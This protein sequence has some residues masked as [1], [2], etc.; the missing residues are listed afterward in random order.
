MEFLSDVVARVRRDLERD[1]PDEPALMARAISMP[2]SRD[3]SGALKSE[4]PAVIAEIERSSPWS[5]PAGDLDPRTL[6]RAF[7]AAGAAA[8]SVVTEGRH[9][10]GTLSDLRAAHLSTRLP[11]LR[12]DF[13]V[14]PAQV[15]ESRAHGADA[16]LLI[17]AALPG[18]ELGAM[19]R[20]TLDLGMAALA[21]AHSERELERV[22][23][24]E[25]E[26]VCINARDLE[27]LALDEELALELIRRTS[28]DR[29]VV[30]AGA[31]SRRDQVEQATRAGASGVVVGE[32]AL[33][34]RNP[35]AKIRQLRGE[36]AVVD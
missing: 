25:A 36:L 17:A 22:L 9:F 21:E 5:G 13:L 20:A 34:A 7:E 1:P 3:F 15:M 6:A 26:M 29:A 27:S 35:A 24:T 18:E 14:H 31:V 32:A 30:F 28:G 8:L 2:P 33:R 4:R 12:H 10:D 19:V 11:V 16:V 23:A